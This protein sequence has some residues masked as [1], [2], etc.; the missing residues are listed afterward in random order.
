MKA[1]LLA[2]WNGPF[3]VGPLERPVSTGDAILKILE[4]AWRAGL[5]LIAIL[6]IG[7]ILGELLR[8]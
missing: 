6:L 8:N 2:L 7:S 5:L 1:F 4:T 3:H